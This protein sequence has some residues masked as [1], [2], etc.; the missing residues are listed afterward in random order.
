MKTITKY[1][2]FLSPK[3]ILARKDGWKTLLPK[4]CAELMLQYE[5]SNGQEVVAKLEADYGK[6][7]TSIIV[8]LAR[9]H[10]SNPEMNDILLNSMLK[11]A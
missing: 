11:V 10:V 9:T 6:K 5:A 8:D 7:I 4:H 2:K 3:T 1:H